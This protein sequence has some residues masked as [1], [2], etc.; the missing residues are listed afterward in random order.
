LLLYTIPKAANPPNRRPYSMQQCNDMQATGPITFSSIFNTCRLYWT[1][2][3]TTN[4]QYNKHHNAK[5]NFKTLLYTD[6]KNITL[7]IKNSKK[8][9]QKRF[10]K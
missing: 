2:T 9:L 8:I 3:D 10:R 4:E 7:S 5:K 6:Y 1:H